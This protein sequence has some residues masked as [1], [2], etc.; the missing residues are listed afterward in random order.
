MLGNCNSRTIEKDLETLS[1]DLINADEYYQYFMHDLLFAY[2]LIK[3]DI[4]NAREAFY[5]LK[6]L[7][8]PLL[9]KYKPIF[10]KRRNVQEKL[11]RD[12]LKIENDPIKYHNIIAEECCHIQDPSS[13]F[14]GRGFLL[15][16]LQFLSF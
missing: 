2:A 12:P 3:N 7:D 16:D 10:D 9:D 6:S 14:F 15:S 8:V 11:L 5:R 13:Y 1:Q 4:I